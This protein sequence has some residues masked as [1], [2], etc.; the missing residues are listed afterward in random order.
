[1]GRRETCGSSLF[2]VEVAHA[3]ALAGVSV[4]V[5]NDIVA[6]SVP[7]GREAGVAMG[8]ILNANVF[9]ERSVGPCYAVGN[10]FAYFG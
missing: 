8:L 7:F 3:D 4:K 6:D 5:G 2:F 9:E 1:M 10:F